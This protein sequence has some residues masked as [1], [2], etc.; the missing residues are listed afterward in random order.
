MSETDISKQIKSF[1]KCV[2]IMKNMI[3]N[4]VRNNTLEEKFK[5]KNKFLVYIE[6]KFKKFNVQENER[7]IMLGLVEKTFDFTNTSPIDINNKKY[8]KVKKEIDTFLE[9]NKNKNAKKECNFFI[10]QLL[11][12]I[13]KHKFNTHELSQL[14]EYAFKQKN[15]DKKLCELLVKKYT[16]K[17]IK[18]TVTILEKYEK[19]K[20]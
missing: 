6:E 18:D 14:L 8:K 2:A 13:S 12:I 19:S 4:G 5:N 10:D 15:I 1:K 9:L 7:K 20:K 11:K 3:N 17:I 16:L